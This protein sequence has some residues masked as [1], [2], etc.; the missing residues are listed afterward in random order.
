MSCGN[1]LPSQQAAR[2]D[3]DSLTSRAATAGTFTPVA[4]QL[5]GSVAAHEIARA[6]GD[7]VVRATNKLRFPILCAAG[8]PSILL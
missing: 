5:A 8:L 6:V 3:S 2:Q 1:S 7:L 4:F